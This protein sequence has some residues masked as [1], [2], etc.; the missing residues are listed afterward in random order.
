VNW[1][2]GE[3]LQLAVDF[4]ITHQ[5]EIFALSMAYPS[6]FPDTPPMVKPR[7]SKRLSNHQY[8]A[9]GELC[10]EHRP[11]NW[12]P[13][14]SGAMMIESAHQL[15]SGERPENKEPAAVPSAHQASV[16]RELRGENMRFI[17]PEEVLGVLNILTSDV[18]VPIQAWDG[19]TKPTWVAAIATLGADDVAIWSTAEPRPATALS[20]RGFAFRT[21]RNVD[22]FQIDATGFLDAL[23][24]VFPALATL[25]PEDFKGFILLGN[26]SRWITLN[27]FPH[28]GK[29][30]VFNYKTLI[31]PATAGRLP[32]D[33]AAL[34]GKH[35]AI[36]GC[37]SVGSKMAVMLA[38]AGIRNFTLVDE[39][40]FFS[41][42]LVRNE[43]DAG[44]I[45]L[46]KVDALTARLKEI[47]G[48]VNINCRRV[49]LGQQESAGT[50][51]SVMED[52]SKTD[53]VIDATADPR[54][55]NLVGA[56][57]RRKNRPMVWC[58]V[59]AGGIGGIVARLRP[60]LDPVPSSA[61]DQIQTWCESHGIPWQDG[62][63]R[64]YSGRSE[65][66]TP[67]VA[68]DADVSVIAAH[69]ARMALDT[70][71]RQQSIFPA[72][73]YA[74]GLLGKWIFA[75]PFDTW[76]IDL[77]LDGTWG[78]VQG[79]ASGEEILGFLKELFPEDGSA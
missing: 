6:T 17:I 74:I 23:P 35:V 78:A 44:A 54:A 53:L 48:S 14:V 43:L 39:D 68:D 25:V 58:Q 38:R 46:H 13:A 63:D 77:R 40:V 11:D 47:A 72:S 10:L 22:R 24:T 60:G 71:G 33:Y 21:E 50:T 59:F 65:D 12:D 79:R 37:G 27:L 66:G 29:R 51:E 61:R 62:G 34:A 52:L 41:A 5:G 15:I 28:E 49:A 70:L 26:G 45:G 75:A 2:V 3:N 56:V 76:P 30:L 16:G 64:D 32:S 18:P 67:L 55:F 73:A 7:D 31:A 4:D 1:R 36:V 57:S 19:Y 42:N 9:G 8:G 20:A 69:A